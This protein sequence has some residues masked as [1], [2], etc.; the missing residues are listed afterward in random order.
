MIRKFETSRAHL[1]AG[2]MGLRRVANERK[3]SP[4][5]AD[6]RMHPFGIAGLHAHRFPHLL[7]N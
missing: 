7:F 1:A 2:M 3:G 4:V 6:K 5:I